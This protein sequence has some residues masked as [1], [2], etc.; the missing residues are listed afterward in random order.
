LASQP[1][2]YQSLI[3]FADELGFFALEAGELLAKSRLQQETCLVKSDG[4]RII[5]AI[6]GQTESGLLVLPNFDSM[7]HFSGGEMTLIFLPH[8][9]IHFLSGLPCP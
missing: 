1:Q 4:S 8:Q 2:R 9:S 7:G 6:L 5:A 3:G